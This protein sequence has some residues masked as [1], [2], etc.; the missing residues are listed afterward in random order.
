ML[1]VLIVGR[2]DRTVHDVVSL[3]SLGNYVCQWVPDDEDLEEQI[4]DRAPDIVILAVD[5]PQ[6]AQKI[7]AT[8]AEFR[9]ERAIPTL[10]WVPKILLDH[11]EILSSVDDFAIAPCE[12][13]EVIIRVGRMATEAFRVEQGVLL[14]CG[15]LAIDLSRREVAVAGR[16]LSLTYKEYELLQFLAANRGRVFGRETLLNK[17]WGYDYYGGDRTVDVHVRRLRSKIEEG[18]HRFIETVRGMGYR[19]TET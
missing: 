8:I 7:I 2:N 3:L 14:R 15:D 12:S 6:H 1:R 5:Q 11:A 18:H 17:I 16:R 19:F 9:L 4:A 13:A 10:A